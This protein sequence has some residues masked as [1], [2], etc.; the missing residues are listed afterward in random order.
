MPSKKKKNIFI[1]PMAMRLTFKGLICKK[2]NTTPQ[3]YYLKQFY[4]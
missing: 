4:V 1:T 2:F 3:G